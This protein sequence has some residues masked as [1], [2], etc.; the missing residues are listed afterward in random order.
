MFS[1]TIGS[2]LMVPKKKQLVT[3]ISERFDSMCYV[4]Y[5]RI[6]YYIVNW[7]W[8]TIKAAMSTV[9]GKCELLFSSSTST[10]GRTGTAS[11]KRRALGSFSV[12]TKDSIILFQRKNEWI[13]QERCDECHTNNTTLLKNHNQKIRLT[14]ISGYYI[15]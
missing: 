11:G 12:R 1:S 5:I 13:D 6:C 10:D 7:E 4:K 2:H 9:D 15:I 14:I 8:L 3:W